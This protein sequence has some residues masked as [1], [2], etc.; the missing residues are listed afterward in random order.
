MPSCESNCVLMLQSEQLVVLYASHAARVFVLQLF[1]TCEYGFR[2]GSRR[3]IEQNGRIRTYDRTNPSLS[4]CSNSYIVHNEATD[5]K[6]LRTRQLTPDFNV[7]TVKSFG[8]L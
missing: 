6:Y 1:R 3:E 5:L 4:N 7:L 2:D 8:I